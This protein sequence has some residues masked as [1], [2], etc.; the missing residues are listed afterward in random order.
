MKTLN[1]TYQVQHEH[2]RTIQVTQ[3]AVEGVRQI[4]QDTHQVVKEVLKTQQAARQIQHEDR[5]TL[6]DTQRAVEDVRQINQD[7]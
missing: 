5:S 7:T 1:E 3:Q 4:N 6:Q 2:H